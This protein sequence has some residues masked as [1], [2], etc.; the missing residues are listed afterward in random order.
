MR[1]HVRLYFD[2]IVQGHLQGTVASTRAAESFLDKSAEGK[3]PFGSGRGVTAG[4]RG[5]K[6]PDG[7]NDL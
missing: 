2:Q 4:C 7:L 3:N 6:G 5:R 1:G